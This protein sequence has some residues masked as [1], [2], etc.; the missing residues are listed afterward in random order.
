ME[1]DT[2][3]TKVVYREYPDGEIIALFPEIDWHYGRC[4][5]FLHVGQ[6]GE[7]DYA[8]VIRKTRRPRDPAAVA[9]L[10]DELTRQHGYRLRPVLRHT[11][12]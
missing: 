4:S 6:H 2:E 5:S 11:R 7:A 3:E 12:R 9:T 8:L 1:M 10:A